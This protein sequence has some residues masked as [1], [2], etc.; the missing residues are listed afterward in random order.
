MTKEKKVLSEAEGLSLVL[1]L[2]ALHMG[3]VNYQPDLLRKYDVLDWL[4]NPVDT[5]ITKYDL[6]DGKEEVI[7]GRDFR[8]WDEVALRWVTENELDYFI[9]EYKNEYKE[10]INYIYV[11]VKEGRID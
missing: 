4:L 10:G 6:K 3:A 11:S 9:D 1:L 7:D 2:I 5:A 8:I